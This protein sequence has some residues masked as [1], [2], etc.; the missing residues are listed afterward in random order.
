MRRSLA[1]LIE[2]QG[3]ESVKVIIPECQRAC[4]AINNNIGKGILIGSFPEAER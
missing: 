1:V 4:I 2:G 3:I